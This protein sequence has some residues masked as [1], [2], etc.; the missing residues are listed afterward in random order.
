MPVFKMGHVGLL[1]LQ[2]QW[3]S[4]KNENS[5]PFVSYLLGSRR[6]IEVK[7]ISDAMEAGGVGAYNMRGE[8]EQAGDAGGSDRAMGG[9]DRGRS[10]PGEEE[11]EG[12]I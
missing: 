6:P 8:A 9:D 5:L 11:E 4:V 1:I 3:M 12:K 2:F 7:S 10:L